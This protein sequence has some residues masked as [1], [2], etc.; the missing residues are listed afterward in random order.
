MEIK[1]KQATGFLITFNLRLI[2]KTEVDISYL[3]LKSNET[4]VC[5]HLPPSTVA[6]TLVISLA[7]SEVVFFLHS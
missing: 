6:A 5:T 2:L 3:L 4:T 7:L 1:V